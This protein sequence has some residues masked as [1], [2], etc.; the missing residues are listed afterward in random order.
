MNH[1]VNGSLKRASSSNCNERVVED[2]HNVKIG[3]EKS[4]LVYCKKC[5][6][7]FQ[8]M[9]I[10]LD[11]DSNPIPSDRRHSQCFCCLCKS[12]LK[13]KSTSE[14]AYPLF[15]C[16]NLNSFSYIERVNERVCLVEYCQTCNASNR[17]QYSC[18][19]DDGICQYFVND[20]ILSEAVSHT[21]I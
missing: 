8:D 9:S 12:N 3:F 10:S 5:Q 18:I 19:K 4:T 17:I 1:D 13:N 15:S 2:N 21:K 7:C 16:K 6:S 14:F 11:D 20:E